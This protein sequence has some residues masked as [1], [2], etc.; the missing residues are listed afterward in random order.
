MGSTIFMVIASTVFTVHNTNTHINTNYIYISTKLSFGYHWSITK[1]LFDFLNGQNL[2]EQ[3]WRLTLVTTITITT[4]KLTTTSSVDF[5]A[6]HCHFAICMTGQKHF[7]FNSKN[8]DFII[9][10]I[11]FQSPI[12]QSDAMSIH[13][14]HAATKISNIWI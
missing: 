12:N 13:W 1:N 11:I 9:I 8:N 4:M 10:V 6:G 3:Y 7:H 14:R 5:T 2:T